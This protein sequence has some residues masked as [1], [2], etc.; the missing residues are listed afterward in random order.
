M[1]F[2]VGLLIENVD[3]TTEIQK[4]KNI[5]QVVVSQ[6]NHVYKQIKKNEISPNM[7]YLFNGLDEEN[8]T[9]GTI[10]KLQMMDSITEGN[11]IRK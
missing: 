8:I 3:T 6:I 1:Y 11:F 4:D 2:A 5:L 10:K 7:E 9:E